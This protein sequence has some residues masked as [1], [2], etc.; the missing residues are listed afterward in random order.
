L[1]IGLCAS[2]FN[3]ANPSDKSSF[4]IGNR[5]VNYWVTAIS[6]HAAD[7]SDWLF[8]GFPAAI[9][10]GGMFN[11]WVAIGL[12]IGMFSAWQFIAPAI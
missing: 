8:M 2:W 11:V 4:L 5:S 3:P 9:Y 6:A 7:M 10:L 12:M 1:V